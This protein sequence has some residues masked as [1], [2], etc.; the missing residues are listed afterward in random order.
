MNEL[1]NQSIKKQPI[2]QS[3]QRSTSLEM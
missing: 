3:N 1:I 2:T